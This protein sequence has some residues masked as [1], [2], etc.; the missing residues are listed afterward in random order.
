MNTVVWN[1]RGLNDP[2]KQVQVAKRIRSLNVDIACFLETRVKS[3]NF[4]RI[5]KK[6]FMGWQSLNNYSHAINGCIWILWKSDIPLNHVDTSEQHITM[7]VT[8]YQ[9]VF[10]LTAAYCDNRG[11]SRRRLWMQLRNLAQDIDSSSWILAGNFNCFCKLDESSDFS[12]NA[13]DI[14]EFNECLN[15]IAVFDHSFT[16]PLFT[17]SKNIDE[18]PLARKLDRVLINSDWLLHFGN[19]MVEFLLPEISDHCLMNIIT[20]VKIFSP[21]KPF[22]FFN[23]WTKHDDFL[24]LV[25]RVWQEPVFGNPMSRLFNKLKNLKPHLTNFNREHFGNLPQKVVEKKAEIVVL[26]RNL[27]TSPDTNLVQRHKA[28]VN[29]F[30]ELQ[31]AVESYYRQK[32]RILW[33]QEGDLNTGFFHKTMKI[34]HNRNTIK[35]LYSENGDRLDT[36]EAI[37][38][39]A[40]NYYK[41]FLGKKDFNISGCS[42]DILQDILQNSLSEEMAKKII[43]PV[44]AQE[45]KTTFFSLN[46]HKAP[47][48]DGYSAH[49][50]R[51]L[52]IL[53][54]LVCGYHRPNMSPRCALKI[55]LKKAFDTLDWDFILNIFKALKFPDLFIKWISACITYPKFSVSVNGGLEGYFSGAR[56]VRQAHGVFS[57]HPKCKKIDL[58]HLSFVD[59]LL[60]F[61]KGNILSILGIKNLLELFYQFSSL[62]M[63]CSKSEIFYS[64]IS[65]ESMEEIQVATVFRVGQLLVRYL[66]VPLVTKSLNVR[67]CMPLVERI[68]QR[69]QSW[70]ARNV[71]YAVID[72]ISQI[73]ASYLWKGK[74]GSSRGA[75]VSWESIYLP[76]S[77]GSVWISWVSAYILKGRDI[78]FIPSLPR[79]SW[80]FKKLLSLRILVNTL[81]DN[82][83]WHFPGGK[84]KIMVYDS[85]KHRQN[86]VEWKKQAGDW[87]AEYNWAMQGFKGKSLLTTILKLAWTSFCYYIWLERN[88][89]LYGKSPSSEDVIFGHIQD[90]IRF[91]LHGLTR[92]GDDFIN[93]RLC[94]SWNIVIPSFCN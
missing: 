27:L 15:D 2:S 58:T 66:G 31:K 90:A 81:Q 5:L 68:T 49:F 38:D 34:R 94:A 64:G 61:T 62:S 9:K 39:E 44:T 29:D 51:K 55:D 77:E 45:I 21:P 53:W 6:H 67:D 11:I 73:C 41:S 50:S 35:L 86:K 52:G 3:P 85:L 84:Y 12:G 78:M 30:H 1:M 20:D 17:W 82:G 32:S 42:V 89:R 54:E 56:G 8:L 47:G 36:Y 87:F 23:F 37:R 46:S 63:N 14:A 48:P 60:I 70:A 79:Y 91:K 22:K 75:K 25:N 59:D 7:K 76:K 4:D 16:G 92:V 24:P 40:V 26:Q 65:D 69:V 74:E 88:A 19:S 10:Y 72:K 43:E 80:A 83:E 57:F 71:S 13:S 28:A 18:H 93:R 33:L